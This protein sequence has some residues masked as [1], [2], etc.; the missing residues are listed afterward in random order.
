MPTLFVDSASFNNVTINNSLDVT[1]NIF[2]TG[3]FS[4]TAGV[5]GS[6]FGTSSFAQQ[7]I[8]SSYITA[9]NI[10]GTYLPASSSYSLQTGYSQATASYYTETGATMD[11]AASYLSSS[12]ITLFSNQNIAIYATGTAVTLTA[13]VLYLTS[14]YVP[15]TATITGCRVYR[16]NTTSFVTSSDYNGMGLYSYDGAG[17]LNIVASSSNSPTVWGPGAAAITLSAFSSLTSV[18]PGVYY[19]G[20]LYNRTSQTTAPTLVAATS[21]ANINLCKVDFTN[22]AALYFSFGTTNTSLPT[23]IATSACTVLTS[24]IYTSL[25]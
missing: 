7:A 1:S 17:T 6:I 9:S 10:N 13:G 5:T 12:N 14:I 24:R 21:P 3:T 23:S 2:V 19:I 18:S 11:L 22:S 20:I 4:T 8:S 25:Y 16:S 15:Y